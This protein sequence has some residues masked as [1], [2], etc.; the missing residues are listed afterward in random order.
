MSELPR[1]PS[2]EHLRKQA[3]RLARAEGLKLAAA[4]HRL[5]K[6]YGFANWAALMRELARR[7]SPLSDAAARGD[8]EAVRALLAEGAAADGAPHEVDAPLYLACD[9]DAP[10][11]AKLAVAELLIEAG[12]HLQRGNSHG[13]TALHAAARRG[14]A[15]LVERLLKA[16]ALYWQGDAEDRRAYDYAAVGE[17]ADRERI[18][19]LTADGPKI[20]DG[21]FRAA[22]AA[23]QAGDTVALARLLDARPE[24]L[25]MAA[26]EPE[27]GPRGY[28]S[29]PR[30]FWFI[31]NNPTLVPHSPANIVEVAR[32]MIERGVARE[33]LEYALGLVATN[34]QM[35]TDLQIDLVRVLID[36]GA[37]V[38]ASDMAGVLGHRQTALVAWLVEHGLELTAPIAAALGRTDALPALLARATP[39]ERS[40]ALGLAVINGEGGAARLSLEA[41]ADP[42]AF[43][44]CH[45]H[46]TPLHQAALEGRIDLM[47]L[48]VAHGA[49]LDIEDRLWRGTPLGW[50]MHNGRKEAE[51][52]LRARS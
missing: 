12:A 41:G 28:F 31:A 38:S 46:S 16:G 45:T 19:Y 43:M 20:E 21:D 10:D 35:P 33:D 49:R 18:L 22:V 3:K 40:D 4:Q 26:I 47:E 23:V 1:N 24:L 37:R 51:A 32:L 14:P 36:A 44:P 5:A 34:M 15:A 11:A 17:G 42:D 8:F 9:G 7:R 29:D 50:A 48:L 25:D 30:L 52:W 27:L 13:A 39:A 6:D 2:A